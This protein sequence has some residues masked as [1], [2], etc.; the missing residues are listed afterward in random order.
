MLPGDLP[1]WT[2][3]SCSSLKRKDPVNL[4]FT[5]GVPAKAR[6]ARVGFCCAALGGD[7]WFRPR[8]NPASGSCDKQDEQLDDGKCLSRLVS[9][10]SPGTVC[11]RR[12]TRLHTRLYRPSHLDAKYGVVTAA[13]I[14]QDRP[15]PW[16][17]GG[18]EVAISFNGPRDE[19]ARRLKAEGHAVTV[20]RTRERRS[21]EQCDGSRVAADG[22]IVLIG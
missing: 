16:R 17:V 21:I 2:V 8:T 22:R 1:F 14:H 5:H 13:P 10:G 11:V 7:Q 19:V 18:W 6:L 9:P 15:K 4:V 12:W 3:D 20:K